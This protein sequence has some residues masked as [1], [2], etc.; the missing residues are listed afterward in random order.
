MPSVEV[1]VVADFTVLVAVE[2]APGSWEVTVRSTDG[3]AEPQV[4]G[5]WQCTAHMVRDRL[6]F[7]V[8]WHAQ[9]NKPEEHT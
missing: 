9:D 3:K 6:G 2:I 1:R 7:I 4:I 8:G 5:Y